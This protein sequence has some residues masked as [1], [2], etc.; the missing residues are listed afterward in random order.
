MLCSVTHCFWG[1]FAKDEVACGQDDEDEESSSQGEGRVDEH[2]AEAGVMPIEAC[3]VLAH[4]NHG[5]HLQSY[6]SLR[7]SSAES[8]PSCARVKAQ[9]AGLQQR[10][11]SQTHTWLGITPSM[12]RIQ[13]LP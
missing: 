13:V 9:S 12:A 6:T 10:N 7:S 3:C 8:S 5:E 1:L 11:L 2:V 4:R